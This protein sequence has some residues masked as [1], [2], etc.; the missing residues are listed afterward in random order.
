[1]TSAQ[2][3]EFVNIAATLRRYA[4]EDSKAKSHV[5]AKAYFT[6]ATMLEDAIRKQQARAAATHVEAFNIAAGIAVAPTQKEA[7][8]NIEAK[9]KHAYLNGDHV[10]H[11]YGARNV[12]HDT[13][14]AIRTYRN[15][16]GSTLREAK[17][18]VDARKGNW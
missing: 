7:V 8:E 4:D 12:P 6:A 14:A 17:D 15:L 1:M 2:L 10:S 13:V 3:Q 18:W 9:C 5:K 16:T 11:M